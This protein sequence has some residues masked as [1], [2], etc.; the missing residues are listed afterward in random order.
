M[1]IE[2]SASRFCSKLAPEDVQRILNVSQV[3]TFAVDS[4]V[5][6]EGDPGSGLYV[7]LQGSVD[8]ISPRISNKTYV[9]SHMETGNYFGEMAV[10]D[11]E[12]RSATA[13]VR[14][15]LEAVFIP[16]GA[17]RELVD[18]RPGLGAM[19]IR[20]ASLRLREFNQ[21][22]LHESLRGERLALVERLARSIAHD[23]RNPLSVISLAAEMAAADTATPA[24]RQESLR[25]IQKHVGILNQMM[26]EL[27]DFTR[28][29]PPPVVLPRVQL[30][31]FLRDVLG[32]LQ[33]EATRKGV[34]LVVEGELPAVPVRLDCPR[35]ARV[36][37]N[38]SENAFDAM[39]G[40]ANPILIVRISSEPTQVAMS[41]VDQGKGIDAANLPHIFEPFFT[42]GKAEGT[43]LGLPICERIVQDHGGIISVQSEP[44]HGATFTVIL[45]VLP[46]E[47]GN[48]PN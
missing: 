2:F 30:S 12:P 41:F 26:Q 32:D 15:F 8:I 10:F 18:Q 1:R 40:M 16:V 25:R 33:S 36:F 19:L 39:S 17:V 4:D 9:L 24:G 47:P 29:T 45:P 13:R 37:M 31:D 23:F 5:F 43:G 42:H 11:G 44:G 21:R 46:R 27:V 14:E 7:I 28:G 38:L 3:R 20:D 6:R 48:G 35:F 22:F 34:R